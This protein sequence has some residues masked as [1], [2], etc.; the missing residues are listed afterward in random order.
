MLRV[1]QGSGERARVG[2]AVGRQLGTAVVRNRMRR[3]LRE[4]VRLGPP[5]RARWDVVLVAR[6]AC[7]DADWPSLVTGW[8]DAVRRAGLC[9]DGPGG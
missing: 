2:I 9:G 8:R 3:R 6:A 4:I 7:R 5:L 1:I